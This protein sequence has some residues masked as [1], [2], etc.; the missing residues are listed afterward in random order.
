MRQQQLFAVVDTCFIWRMISCL[1]TKVTV[2]S[3][4]LDLSLGVPT[5]KWNPLTCRTC[6]TMPAS[7]QFMIEGCNG[8]KGYRTQTPFAIA[9]FGALL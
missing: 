4:V 8:D 1:S 9:A 7:F 6:H 3:L 5:W 2:H